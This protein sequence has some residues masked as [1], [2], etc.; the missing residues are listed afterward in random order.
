[1]MKIIKILAIWILLACAAYA[2]EQ[3]RLDSI[4]AI[5]DKTP[6]TQSQL[7]REIDKIK[8]Q[9]NANQQSMPSEQQLTKEVLSLLIDKTL[10]LNLAKQMNMSVTDEQ[11]TQHLVTIAERNDISVAKLKSQLKD[12]QVDGDDFKAEMREQLLL[13]ELQRK[14]VVGHIHLSEGE[15]DNMVTKLQKMQAQQVEYKL[16]HVFVPTEETANAKDKQHA[17]KI[18]EQLAGDLKTGE[19]EIPT[20]IDGI[21]IEN[22]QWNW[23]SS[24]QLP[25]LFTESLQRLKGTD[26]TVTTPIMAANGFHVL[27]IEGIRSPQTDKPPIEYHIKQIVL[28]IPEPA[29]VQPVLNDITQIRNRLLKG[30]N[31]TTLARRYSQQPLSASKGGDFGWIVDYEIPPDILSELTKLKLGAISEP[32]RTSSAWYLIE[33]VGERPAKNDKQNFKLRARNILLQ[34]KFA[35][36]MQNWLTSLRSQAF[37]QKYI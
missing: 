7:N 24:A 5:V 27:Q 11:V 36:G 26:E 16:R 12:E 10:Q 20:K 28:K 30:E 21:Q 35:I 37:I 23:L 2:Q 17:L 32:I 31:F 1:M 6:I 3:V 4:V 33:K 15:I 14:E 18:A 29:A 22:Q 9:L 34:Q 25:Q 8:R 19:T 13:H